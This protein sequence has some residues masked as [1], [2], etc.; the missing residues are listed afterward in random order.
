M[1]ASA[2]VPLTITYA[3]DSGATSTATVVGQ[4]LNNGATNWIPSGSDGNAIY[5]A[6]SSADG[7]EQTVFGGETYYITTGP[8]LPAQ[9]T[10]SVS[11][12]ASGSGSAAATGSASGSGGMESS[13][14]EETGGSS[15]MGSGGAGGAEESASSA[16]GDMDSSASASE[17]AAASESSE[18]NAASRT[19]GAQGS[20][21][22]LLALALMTTL[23]AA[24]VYV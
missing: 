19:A 15:S 11:E 2:I 4:V 12:A 21:R 17:S 7:A 13:G 6:P 18:G 14:A 20:G 23:G 5:L 10:I 22:M 9:A 1:S 8:A 24:L 3:P 16:G